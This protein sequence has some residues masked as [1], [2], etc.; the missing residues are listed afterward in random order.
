MAEAQRCDEQALLEAADDESRADAL[1]GLAADAVA[2]G[3]VDRAAS[4][5]AASAPPAETT[6]RTATRYRWVRAELALARGGH[7][8]DDALAAIALAEGHSARHAAKSRIMADASRCAAGWSDLGG[9]LLRAAAVTRE[10]GL[11]TLQWPLGLVALDVA[12]QGRASEPL[13]EALPR[14]LREGAEAASFIADHLP[15]EDAGPWRARVELR[16][17]GEM[18]HRDGE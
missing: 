13:L 8:V 5:L 10:Q 14:L 6:W 17:L 4:F 3:D 12:E 15:D 16:R 1:I 7:S 2:L 11:A 9:D 18:R